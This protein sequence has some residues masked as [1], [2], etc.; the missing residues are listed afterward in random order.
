M[1]KHIYPDCPDCGERLTPRTESI[2]PHQWTDDAVFTA[3][4]VCACG[5]TSSDPPLC[6]R[7]ETLFHVRV[8][9]LLQNTELGRLNALGRIPFAWKRG[10]YAWRFIA[11]R[12]IGSYRWW[13]FNRETRP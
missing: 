1:G 2:E 6:L 4:V 7:E 12:Q 10:W 13:T 11:E 3:G 5:Y 9:T 8:P